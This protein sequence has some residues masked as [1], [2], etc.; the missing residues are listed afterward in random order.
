MA[1]TVPNQKIITTKGAAH[2]K[3]NT[4][5]QISVKA[6]ELAMSML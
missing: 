5:C 2:D 3:Q 6:M 1:T 4:Y